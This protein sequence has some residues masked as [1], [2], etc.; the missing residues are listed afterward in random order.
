MF[1]GTGTQ[2][3]TLFALFW[4]IDGAIPLFGCR[5]NKK[6]LLSRPLPRESK[7]PRGSHCVITRAPL[8]FLRFFKHL[9][10]GSWSSLCCSWDYLGGFMSG[11]MGLLL[12]DLQ[13]SMTR[14]DNS[15]LY[16]KEHTMFAMWDQYAHSLDI[17]F[18]CVVSMCNCLQDPS[19]QS[20]CLNWLDSCSH[21]LSYLQSRD[22]FQSNKYGISI[23]RLDRLLVSSLWLRENLFSNTDWVLWPFPPPIF[24]LNRA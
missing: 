13:L 11:R 10:S 20:I 4:L 14:Q 7:G 15:L 22:P 17:L 9:Y 16:V 3:D 5:P 6:W 2:N 12:E 24:W 21:H 19:T 23:I 8:H 1:R 18:I